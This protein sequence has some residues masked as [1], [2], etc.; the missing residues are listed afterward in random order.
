MKLKPKNTANLRS[1]AKG[2]DY[3]KELRDQLRNDISGIEHE[4]TVLKAKRKELQEQLLNL[5]IE[6]FYI[7]GYALVE[8]P[9]GRNKKWQKCILECESGLLYAR[10]VKEDNSLSGRHFGVCPFP[11]RTYAD[12]L[13]EV[14]E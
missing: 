3:N 8:I 2:G 4:I 12:L 9:S 6:P 1:H 10:P 13:K 11:N 14:D 5:E 7:G